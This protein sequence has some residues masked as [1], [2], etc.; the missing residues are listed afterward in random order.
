[1][2]MYKVRWVDELLTSALRVMPVTV[3]TGARQTGKTTAVR[4]LGA[5]RQFYSLD[6]ISILDLAQRDASQLLKSRPVT[7]D[8]AQRAP[9]LFLAVKQAVDERR[10]PGDFIL[11][12]SA[13]LNLGDLV[14]ESLAGRALYLELPPFCPAEW[15]AREGRLAPLDQLFE[16]SFDPGDWPCEEGAWAAWLL[17]GGFAP[18]LELASDQDRGLWLGSYVQTYLERDLRQL[19]AISSLPDFQRLMVLAAHRCARLLNQADLARDAALSHATAHR[20]INLLEAG[21]LITRLRPYTAG[22]ARSVVRTPKLLWND[23]GLAAWL[24]GLR[25]PDDVM[26]RPDTGF[27][28][29]Q[30]IFMTLQTWRA[31]DPVERRLYFWR[32]KSG[33]E[34]DFVLEKR[35][36][37]VAIELKLGGQ[38]SAGDADGLRAFRD[39]LKPG[40]HLVRSVVM[41]G[42][43][44]QP[45]GSDI[46]ALPWG[47]LVPA[48]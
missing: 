32:D 5:G 27:W 19:S 17:R 23:C 45:L 9:G 6:D 43:T 31:L 29:E 39:S 24:A 46:F 16:E 4:E 35:G 21:F 3:V 8:E 25:R 13:N 22:S 36:Q 34:V 47:W 48:D 14:S 30:A 18:S 28:L 26:K 20:Y 44:A 38:V 11:T 41:H 12:G 33:R 1:M 40:Q 2:K 42:G 7:I 37:L 15:R 10:H